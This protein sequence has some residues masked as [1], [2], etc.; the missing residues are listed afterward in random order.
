MDV[1]LASEYSNALVEK[2]L[3]EKGWK[4]FVGSES[5]PAMPQRQ[6]EPESEKTARTMRKLARKN[7][8]LLLWL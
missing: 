7:V 6:E 4:N 3:E 8:S 5:L 2:A 1:E